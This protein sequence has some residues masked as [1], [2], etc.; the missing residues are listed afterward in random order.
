MPPELYVAGQPPR[1]GVD[2]AFANNDVPI[3]RIA[4]IGGFHYIPLSVGQVDFS[5][6]AYTTGVIYA[7]NDKLKI[8]INGNKHL[9]IKI[10]FRMRKR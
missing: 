1:I 4:D 6:A 3:F 7:L 9:N 8:S 10:K 2:I 5:G